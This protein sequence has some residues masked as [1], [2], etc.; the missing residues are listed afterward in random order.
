MMVMDGGNIMLKYREFLDL[1]DEEIEFIIKEIFHIQ[2][3]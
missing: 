3:V 1:T 2:D